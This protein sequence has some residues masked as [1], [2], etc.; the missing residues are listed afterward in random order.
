M[1][2][3]PKFTFLIPKNTVATSPFTQTVRLGKGTCRQITITTAP[4][5]KRFTTFV[6]RRNGSQIAPET[7]GETY[8]GDGSTYIVGANFET[9]GGD[10]L[11]TF[12]GVNTDDTF[13]HRYIIQF[14]MQDPPVE[15][16]PSPPEPIFKSVNLNDPMGIF[17]TKKNSIFG[18]I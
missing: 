6:I 16:N 9:H 14:E 10:D 18:G 3:S 13:D 8:I 5:H 15:S 12:V 4:G 1:G 2:R 7:A 17:R 11:I